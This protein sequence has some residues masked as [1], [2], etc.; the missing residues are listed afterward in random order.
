[1]QRYPIVQ[2]F[3]VAYFTGPAGKKDILRKDYSFGY[4]IRHNK[5]IH[6]NHPTWYAHPGYAWAM[7][8]QL[9][10]SIG[11][12]LDFCIIGSADLHFAYALLG[13]M[14]ETYPDGLGKEYRQLGQKW[15]NRLTEV[16]AGGNN[17][18]YLNT[19]LFHRWHGS[20]ESRSY[21]NRWSVGTE[22]SSR[23]A[24]ASICLGRFSLAMDILRCRI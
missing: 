1:M 22:C 8:R 20:R 14:H 13:R 15:A 17:V 11:G 18:G 24:T 12:L 5:P 10:N 23:R 6:P 7:D 21:V 19:T 16:A 4:S 3:R 2:L 9:F